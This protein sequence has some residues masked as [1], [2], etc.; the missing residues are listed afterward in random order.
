MERSFRMSKSDLQARPIFHTRKESIEAHLL[1][2]FTALAVSRYVE[3]VTCAS[4]RSVIA[5]LTRIKEIIVEDPS[6]GQTASKYTN[7]TEEARQLLRKTDVW[8]T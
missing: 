6:T 1:I 2:V 3:M 7:L 4:I 5:T 8:V